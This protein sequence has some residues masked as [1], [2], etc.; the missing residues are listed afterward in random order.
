V[1]LANSENTLCPICSNCDSLSLLCVVKSYNVF[2]CANCS[3]EYVFPSPDEATLKAYYD[4][5]ERFGG[6]EVGGYEDCDTQTDW[7][8][9]ARKL[10]RSTSLCT[11]RHGV[12][13]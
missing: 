11:T 4:G 13:T 2:Q 5:K 1:K 8:I 10:T 9:T 7:S 3:A 6:E 12:M